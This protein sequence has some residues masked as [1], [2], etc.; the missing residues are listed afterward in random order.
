MNEENVGNISMENSPEEHTQKGLGYFRVSIWVKVVAILSI[1]SGGITCLGIISALIGVP[2]IFS[3][4]K[5]LKAYERLKDFEGTNDA[6]QLFAAVEEYNKYF[7]IMGILQIVGIVIAVLYIGFIIFVFSASF[8][9]MVSG[10]G[11]GGLG[12]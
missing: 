8:G 5:L 2:M 1:I 10:M 9:Y 4:V 12:F 6:N 11:S 7:T 3:G